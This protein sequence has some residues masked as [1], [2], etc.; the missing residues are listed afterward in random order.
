MSGRGD[1]EDA[2]MLG[3]RD[4]GREDVWRCGEMAGSVE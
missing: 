1:M 3:R 4:G 2:G